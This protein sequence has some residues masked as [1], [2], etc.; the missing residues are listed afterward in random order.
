[1]KALS[2][3]KT[4]VVSDVY[5]GTSQ[6]YQKLV[7][8]LR[9]FTCDTLVLCGDII[10]ELNLVHLDKLK[11]IQSAFIHI[12][13][14]IASKYG[15]KIVFVVGDNCKNI[16]SLALGRFV[17]TQNFSFHS[18]GKKYHVLPGDITSYFQSSGMG[19][20]SADQLKYSA[21][22]WLNNSYNH[23]NLKKGKAYQ[24]LFKRFPEMK[25]DENVRYSF[26][27][28]FKHD[29]VKL[30]IDKDCEGVIG[31]HLHFSGIY[32]FGGISYLNP[33][34]WSESL[35]ALAETRFGMWRIL[36]YEEMVAA[37]KD[38][39]IHTNIQEK[40]FSEP[41]HENYATKTT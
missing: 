27:A 20:F 41:I 13:D 17:F 40:L 39:Q 26:L 35:T 36:D 22:L 34:Y 30:S 32:Y 23:Y 15:T 5:L 21:L 24:S 16:D 25:N 10:K 37:R 11:N 31:G 1:M 4:V 12:L 38:E 2:H 14:D 33:G 29:I 3:Y 9:A 8:F 18:L 28:R 19:F 7:D 6:D